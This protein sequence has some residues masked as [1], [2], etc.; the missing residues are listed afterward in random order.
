MDLDTILIVGKEP[1][2]APQTPMPSAGQRKKS[3]RTEREWWPSRMC[4]PKNNKGSRG[5][6]RTRCKESCNW[7]Y[8]LVLLDKS[9][10]ENL[11][12]SLD[13]S[14]NMYQNEI[15]TK[16]RHNTEINIVGINKDKAA[17][18]AAMRMLEWL[19]ALYTE[20]ESTGITKDE[21]AALTARRTTE[22]LQTLL[23][24]LTAA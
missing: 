1:L 21:G 3:L 19:R 9:L 12:E 5:H 15:D 24:S 20:F 4:G 23:W 22:R 13:E 17:L 14:S 2:T 11:N 18:Q 16:D 10:N 8:K 6:R 7:D